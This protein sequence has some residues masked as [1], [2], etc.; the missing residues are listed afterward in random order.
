M[1]TVSF[2]FIR[3]R[4]EKTISNIRKVGE[5]IFGYIVS[6]ILLDSNTFIHVWKNVFS[7]ISTFSCEGLGMK[8]AAFNVSQS[9]SLGGV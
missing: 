4:R 1:F 6:S 7:N 8:C 3:N 2:S 5:C 9:N